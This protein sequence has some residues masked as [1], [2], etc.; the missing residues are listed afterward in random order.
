MKNRITETS[1]V[2]YRRDA[3]IKNYNRCAGKVCFAVVIGRQT[4]DWL[5]GWL[6]VRWRQRLNDL[7][8]VL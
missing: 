7:Q 2:S 8:P 4:I 3:R 5:V 6:T 1:L